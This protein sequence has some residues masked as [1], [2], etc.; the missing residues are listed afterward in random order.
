MQTLPPPQA[1]EPPAI[2]VTTSA[3][4]ESRYRDINGEWVLYVEGE[5]KVQDEKALTFLGNAQLSMAIKNLYH[6]R[7][8]AQSCQITGERSGHCS[9]DDKRSVVLALKQRPRTPIPPKT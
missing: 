1:P 3:V 9:D 5:V 4:T 2:S 8:D 6:I 7:W